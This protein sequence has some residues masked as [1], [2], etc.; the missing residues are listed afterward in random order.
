LYRA[1][2]DSCRLAAEYVIDA[3]AAELSRA[4]AQHYVILACAAIRMADEVLRALYSHAD[5]RRMFGQTMARLQVVAHR[6]AD[7]TASYRIA[8]AYL[9]E[10]RN[11]ANPAGFVRHAALACTA[12]AAMVRRLLE[13]AVQLFGGRAYLTDHWVGRLYRDWLSLEPLVSPRDLLMCLAAEGE[14]WS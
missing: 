3:V 4:L 7:H 10:V 13:D 5:T 11:G 1:E 12:V 8:A 9:E 6:L 14:T 2:F